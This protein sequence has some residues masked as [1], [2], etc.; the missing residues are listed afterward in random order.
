MSSW[1]PQQKQLTKT[2]AR[3]T[4]DMTYTQALVENY[5]N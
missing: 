5:P 1:P 3:L 4:G 2:A